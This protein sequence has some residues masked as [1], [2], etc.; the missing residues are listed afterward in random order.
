[1]DLAGGYY[2]PVFKDFL[3]V[4]QVDPLSLNIFNVIVDLAVRHWVSL[5][6]EGEEGPE[7]WGREV[8]YMHMM[9]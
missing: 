4:T 9:A 8:N 5:V 2:G 6:V 7:G 1:M 3:G